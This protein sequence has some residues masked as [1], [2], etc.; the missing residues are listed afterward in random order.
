MF[1]LSQI[2][3]HG[4]FTVF[5]ISSYGAPLAQQASYLTLHSSLFGP[6]VHSYIVTNSIN[7]QLIGSRCILNGAANLAQASKL[8]I[9][10]LFILH[11]YR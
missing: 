6:P 7:S 4:I 5:L 11:I 1:L 10:L 2:L 8:I 9:F 3:A